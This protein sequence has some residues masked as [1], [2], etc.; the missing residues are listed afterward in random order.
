MENNTF[1][2]CVLRSLGFSVLSVGARVSHETTGRHDGGWEGWSHMVNLVRVDGQRYLVD[3]GFGSNGSCRPIALRKD[4]EGGEVC[5]GVGPQ[6][7]RLEFTCLTR[8]TDPEQRVW[9]YSH[10]ETE[11]ES[12][13]E[14]YCFTETEF[15]AEDFEVMN[16]WTMTRRESFFVQNVIAQRF[17]L[18]Q[19]LEGDGEPLSRGMG[20]GDEEDGPK[21]VG[22]M[23]LYGNLAKRRIGNQVQVLAVLESEADRMAALQNYFGIRLSEEEQRGIRDLPTELRG[24]GGGGG[25][26]GHIIQGKVEAP[27]DPTNG[28]VVLERDGANI[29]DTN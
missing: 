26:S 20:T 19:E 21:A 23:I 17:V 2:A 3:A 24:N 4:K 12:W 5:E 27:T 22:V 10:R 11:R 25:E 7:C 29:K 6:Q 28:F 18:E 8:H 9:V 13:T 14:A 1:F 15:F 16:L